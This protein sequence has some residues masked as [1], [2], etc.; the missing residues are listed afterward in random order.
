EEAKKE[1]VSSLKEEAKT[2]AMS[3]IQDTL[4]EAK[5]TAQNDAKKIILST[6]QRIGVEQTV[7]NCVSVFNLESDD[8]KGRIIGR[9]GRNIRALESATGV[10]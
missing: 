6:I 5:L 4:E 2:D 1:L 7:E 10:E 8:V 3:Y 9:E